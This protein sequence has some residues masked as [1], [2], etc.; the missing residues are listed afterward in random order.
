MIVSNSKKYFNSIISVKNLDCLRLSDGGSEKYYGGSQMWYPIRKK[1]YSGCGPTNCSN[2]F[3]YLAMTRKECKNFILHD[4]AT[5]NNFIKLMNEVWNYVTPRRRGVDTLEIF[6][7]GAEGYAR[8]R[9]IPIKC[10]KLAISVSKKRRPSNTEMF[11]FL[12]KAFSDDLP[13]AFLNL[14]SGLAKNLDRWHWVTIVSANKMLGTVTIYD[15]GK[16]SDV[17]LTIWRNSTVLG[18]GFVVIE[19]V[20]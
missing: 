8:K 19:P 6:T 5:K 18:G 4:V 7:E 13:V 20:I 15:Q 10:R 17:N 1:K 14:S 11:D 16:K 3:W 2:L 12:E 9:G